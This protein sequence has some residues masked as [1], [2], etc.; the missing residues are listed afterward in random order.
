LCH[1][2]HLH[3]FNSHFRSCIKHSH[4]FLTSTCWEGPHNFTLSVCL[5]VCHAREVGGSISKIR[6]SFVNFIFGNLWS[7]S[8]VR[9]PDMAKSFP[10][11]ILCSRSSTLAP[12]VEVRSRHTAHFIGEHVSNYCTKLT[13]M[14]ECVSISPIHAY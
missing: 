1:S 5:S 7:T 8:R 11:E 14:F 13:R 3:T 9:L 2:Q 12:L 6:F 4:F 10:P